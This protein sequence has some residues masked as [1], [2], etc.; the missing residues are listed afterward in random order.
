MITPRLV[1]IPLSH[2]GERARWALDHAG[3]DYDEVHTLQ[4]FSWASA[5]RHG[6]HRTLPVLL[7]G[8]RCLDDSSLI[9]DFADTRAARPL[10]PSA[11][12]DRAAVRELSARFAGDF[13]VA[14]R[15]IAYEWFFRSLDTCLTFNAGRAPPYQARLFA[16]APGAV[17]AMAKRYLGVA[18]PAVSTARDLVRRT[19]DE[20]ASRLA[21]GRRYLFGDTFTAADLTFATMAWLTVTPS[22]Y[23]VALPSIDAIPEDARRAIL[24]WREHPAGAFV[25][26]L[27]DERPATRGRYERPLAAA[28]DR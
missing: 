23:P 28:P 25:M 6:R 20:V 15:L 8:D 2:Y 17:S 4:M 18:E 9:I 10:F 5:L 26:R 16:T 13:G 3:I 14:T 19:M 24:G 1:T 12:R 7:L 11:A 21:D 27:Y 22:R